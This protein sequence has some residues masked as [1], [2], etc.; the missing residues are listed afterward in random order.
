MKNDICNITMDNFLSLD[1]NERIPLKITLHLLKCKKC[2]SQVHYLTLA[3]KYAVQPSNQLSIKESLENIDIKPVSM[4][5]WIV[6]G[7]IMIIMLV[8]F[9]LFLNKIDRTSFAIIFN[10]IFGVLVTVYCSLFMATNID[11]FIK[12][13]ERTDF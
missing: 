9:C 7:I 11:F 12:K 2:R 8:I 13:T 10:I 4:T 5:K 6:S 1:K 3:E